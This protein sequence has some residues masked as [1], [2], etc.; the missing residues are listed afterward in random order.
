[1]DYFATSN[2][3][4][5]VAVLATEGTIKAG[6]YQK[7]LIGTQIKDVM[8]PSETEM[9]TLVSPGIAA[10]KSGNLSNAEELLLE[11]AHILRE[12][13]ATSIIMACTEIPLVLGKWSDIDITL[14]DA[15]N[16]LTEY[17]VCWWL[18]N[19]T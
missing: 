3:V 8:I 6:I 9:N 13:G 7:R 10:V 18:K 4:E 19:R 15:T 12:R 16:C 5:T 17:Y 11:A 2:K 1:M 14:V